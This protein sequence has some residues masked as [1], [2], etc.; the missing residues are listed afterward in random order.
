MHQS[1]AFTSWNI[2][3]QAGV[4]GSSNPDPLSQA[5]IR[6]QRSA[7][8]WLT[9]GV[10]KE[11][12]KVKLEHLFKPGLGIKGEKNRGRGRIGKSK[13]RKRGDLGEREERKKEGKE[14]GEEKTEGVVLTVMGSIN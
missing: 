5:H 2:K 14:E 10:E 11:I 12:Q 13:R 6:N 3:V 7:E 9:S 8:K 1:Q 4:V